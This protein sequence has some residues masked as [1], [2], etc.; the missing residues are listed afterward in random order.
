MGVCLSLVEK[1]YCPS[2]GLMSDSCL[3]FPLVLHVLKNS[4]SHPLPP[5]SIHRLEKEYELPYFLSS[6]EAFQ[7]I[8]M[9][10][11]IPAPARSLGT[12]C[13]KGKLFWIVKLRML[14]TGGKNR[15]LFYFRCIDT[16]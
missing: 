13:T 4:K 6:Q 9:K 11:V 14:I 5:I 3:I 8:Q 7:L 2:N 16:K 1:L 12:K 15:H 10:K